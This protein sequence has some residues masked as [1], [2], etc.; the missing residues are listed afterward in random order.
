MEEDDGLLSAGF[1][2]DTQGA[3]SELQRFY[4]FF[5]A[6]TIRVLDEIRRVEDATG[7]MMQLS[8][9]T[10]EVAA[11]S[12][13][14]KRELSAVKETA[15]TIAASVGGLAS[16]FSTTASAATSEARALAREKS[17]TATA[18]EA[19]IRTLDR[20]A[21]SLG[22]TKEEMRAAKVEAIALAAANQGNT[23]LADRLL[24]SA[25]QREFAAVAAA[26]AEEAAARRVTRAMEEQAQAMR[27]ANQAH[28][29]F[30]NR[31]RQGAAAMAAEEREA[32]TFEATMARV[33]GRVDPAA[34]AIGKLQTELDEARLAFDRARISAEAF[35]QEQARV[36][37][38]A[39][40]LYGPQR[41]M[42]KAFQ[43]V[44]TAQRFTAMETLNLSRQFQDIGVTAAMGMNPLMIMVQQGPQIY[45]VLE[46]AKARGVGAGAAFA[47]MGKDI[48]GYAVAGFTRLA[49]LIN[50]VNLLLAGT[51]LA[52]VAVVKSLATYG[53]AIERFETTASGL[54]RISGETA[55]SLEAISEA[56]AAAGQRSIGATRDSVNAFAAAGIQGEQTLTS[57][58]S[59][60]EKYGKL[61]GQDVPAAQA[62]LAEAMKDPARAADTFTQQLGLL[63]GAQYEHIRQ[64]AAQGDQERATSELTRILTADITANAHQT[65]GLAH[66]MDMLRNAVSGVANMFGRLDQKFKD[67]GVT[68][69][70]W[71]KRNVG[72]WAVDLLGSGNQAPMKPGANAGRNQD[73]IAALNASQSMNTSG[74][75]EFNDLLGKQS[76]LQKGLRDTTGLTAAQVQALRHD[77]SAV[78]DTINA[79]RTASG[80]WITTQQ[81]AH[82]VA[83][84]QGRLA[85]ARTQREKAAAQQQITNLRLGAQVLTQQERETQAADAYNKTA[86]RYVKPKTDHHAEQLARESEAMEA[87]IG[88]LYKLAD[89]Y[90]VSGAQ[91]LMAE[92]RV[93]AESGAI[94]KRGDVEAAVAQQIRLA[95]AER[96]SSAEKGVAAMRQQ[97]VI[98]EAVNADVAAGNVPAARAGE[99]LRDRIAD[100]PLLAALEAAQKTN[101]VTGAARVEKA[102]D[103]QR[104]AR[105]RLTKSERDGA[106]IAAMLAGDNQLAQMREELRLIGATDAERVHALAT[107]KATQ[108][109]AGKF[110]GPGG[111]A[112]IKQQV[113][114]ADQGFKNAQAN[115]AY[116][117]SLTETADRWDIIAGKI[118]SAGQGMADAFGESGRALG[119]VVSIFTNYQASRSRAE[120]EHAAAIKKAGANEKLIAQENSRF[121]LR[122]SG[123]QVE[124]FGDL[125]HAALGFFKTGSDGYKALATAEKV[126]RAV[127]F[128]LSVRSIAQDAIETGTKIANT[129]ARTAV[130]GTEAVV[131]AIKSLPF[132]LNLAAGAATAGAIA[133]LGVS[134]VGSFGGGGNKLPASNTGTG[135][136]LGDPEA[137]SDSIK[138]AIDALANVDRLTNT[139]ARG[140]AASLKSIDSQ[141]GGV[142]ALVVRAGNIDAS[143]GVTEGFQKNLVG[144]VLGSI[145]V[146][147]GLLGGL[148]G[149]KTTVVGNGLFGGAQTVGSIMDDG[150]DA[151]YYSDVQKKKK[152]FGLTTGTKYSTQYTGADANLENQFTLILRQF[153]TAIASAAGPL[154]ESTAEIQNRL[155]GFVVDIGKIDLKD[156]TG[157]EIQEKLSAVFG[158]AADGMAAAAFPAV[159]QFQKVGE[160]TFET[161][162]RVASTVEAVGASLDLLGTSAQGMSVAVKLGLADQFDSVADLTNAADAYFQGYYSAAEQAAAKT[163]Q[164]GKVFDSLG[165]AMPATLAGFRQLVEAQDLTSAAGQS[166]YATLLQLAPAFADLKGSME[167]VKS[168]A[169]ILSERENLN[170]Q[171]LELQGDTAAIRALDLAKVDASNRALQQQV[172]AMQDAKAAADAAKQ[173]SDAWTS[174]GNSISDEVRRIRGLSDANGDMGFAAAMGQFNAATA[175]A[176]GGDQDA[177]KLLPGLSQALLK[178]AADAATSRQELDRVQAQTAASL[179][180]TGAVIA[181]IAAGN[182]LTSAGPV[183]AAAAAAQA[184]SPTPAAANDASDAL[185]DLRDEIAQLRADNNAGHAASASAGNR[186]A[187][188]LENVSSASGGDA[189]SVANG[190]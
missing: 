8:G 101:D 91:A 121:A 99:L 104:A 120:A 177:A 161:L 162:V 118:Q 25:R 178:S 71:L 100:L 149:S 80:A 10:R 57:L 38:A 4:Q 83:E 73:Q 26:E 87:Q 122:S 183:T 54:G 114:I 23:D 69:D 174:V 106:L 112:W 49:P 19:L 86:G 9:A 128:A 15:D 143:G 13:G 43:D 46:Q 48:T 172:W 97:V 181:A 64:L 175:A 132:P 58:A 52:I 165:L 146:I 153:N 182:P 139:Y 20:E 187:K 130:S 123:A 168:A 176:R 125:T 170:R 39:G 24:A 167:G 82:M 137:K 68:Y 179:E 163:A 94:K 5:D 74:M 92:A 16:A 85:S 84:A 2:I 145:P 138:N 3:F 7:G 184:A 116:N 90:Q 126:F 127:E 164:F 148:F 45:D 21:A 63:T 152:L 29:M 79:N 141:I 76:V 105:E 12:A 65:T 53:T 166:T 60:V 129:V 108:D 109:A 11:F 47:Q 6:G 34:V 41:D 17:Q 42:A 93:K 180:A 70:A 102:L 31:V 135:T 117:A 189:L 157:A 159:A 81:R 144:S 142:A 59:I 30:E 14:A 140:M 56:A 55:Q 50:P 133:A 72:G 40:K 185:T 66:I 35:D 173:L 32:A 151:S 36:T 67:F 169:D 27:S 89:A 77:Y 95:I 136:V 160:G 171:M 88:N 75:R 186:A 107:L 98:Q 119:D 78:T 44:G 61:T 110:D 134:I 154:G 113:A 37:A 131:N 22:K 150:F 111:A 190:G 1:A 115:D 103:A 147:G 18:G 96:V 156:L 33:Q 124:A 188:V 62:A 155:N 158:A 51:A 28:Q